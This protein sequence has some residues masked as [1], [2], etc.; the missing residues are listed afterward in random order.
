MTA[1]E[2]PTSSAGAA[3]TVS[4]EFYVKVVWVAAVL[5]AGIIFT[6]SAVRLTSSGLGC[7]DWPQCSAD[8]I[9]PEWGFHPWIEFGNR[10]ISLAVSA[11]VGLVVWLA[12]RRTPR[13]SDLV[14]WSWGLVAGVVIQI[15]LGGMT[16]LVDLHPLF[17]AVHFLLSAALMANVLVL[18]AR[19]RAGSADTRPAYPPCRIWHSRVVVLL[20]SL[21][22]V[23]GTLV[24]GTGPHGGDTRADRL[25][26]SLVSIA[27][28]HSLLA[29]LLLAA[30]AAF[31][32]AT[33]AK[34]PPII[35]WLMAILVIQGGI[36]Y[37]QY[38]AG[39]P[40][41]LV[42]LHIVGA[43]AIWCSVI[44]MHLGLFERSPAGRQ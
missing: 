35:R 22:L 40:A 27:R 13:R 5:L 39:I 44:W 36:G 38:A 8:R 16:V 18:A 41:G 15:L 10:L 23:A 42:E 31:A 19:A 24:S 6:G 1:V 14:R 26:L 4:P 20:A 21:V 17:V 2:T 3:R 12:Y 34:P 7:E 29:W 25:D 11:S 43:V 28:A 30:I 33:R 32:L 37:W 9:V